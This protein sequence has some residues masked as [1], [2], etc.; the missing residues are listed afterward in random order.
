MLKQRHLG[1]LFSALKNDNS[2]DKKA[3]TPIKQVP[4]KSIPDIKIVSFNRWDYPNL[5]VWTFPDTK[6]K[7][8]I[9]RLTPTI[10]STRMIDGILKSNA[11]FLALKSP[12]VSPKGILIY[13]R[14]VIPDVLVILTAQPDKTRNKPQLVFPRYRWKSPLP[15]ALGIDH[16]CFV[17]R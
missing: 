13:G 8:S 2:T 14:V 16:V 15:F 10:G 6:F 11:R 17:K 12:T 5:P 3:Y 1:V 7:F 4:A 9:F